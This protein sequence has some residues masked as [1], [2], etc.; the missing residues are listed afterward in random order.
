MLEAEGALGLREAVEERY[1]R[2]RDLLHEVLALEP[3]KET[4][5]LYL[6]LLGQS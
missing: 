3:A 2:P 6:R 5:T 1:G 4:R